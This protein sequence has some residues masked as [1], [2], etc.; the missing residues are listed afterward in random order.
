MARPFYDK[1]VTSATFRNVIGLV[2]M[3]SGEVS[4]VSLNVFQV[5]MDRKLYLQALGY[6][7]DQLAAFVEEEQAFADE[8]AT[9]RRSHSSSQESQ[10]D[11]G[12]GVITHQRQRS[13]GTLPSSFKDKLVKFVARKADLLFKKKDALNVVGVTLPEE[14]EGDLYAIM[15]PL[16]QFMGVDPALCRK[17][18]YT[19]LEQND[20]I[21]GRI[22]NM[23]D[24]GMFVRLLCLC[25]HKNRQCDNLEIVALCPTSEIPRQSSHE[26]PLSSYH[27]NDLLRTRI[28][29]V[30]PSS[31]KILLSLY[32][33]KDWPSHVDMG[34]I[35]ESELPAYY[36]RSLFLEDSDDSYDKMLHNIVGF[37]NPNCV[38]YV[39]NLLGLDEKIPPSMLRALH[40]GK[41]PENEYS[42]NLRK[43][44]T[45]KW[46]MK[47]T[48]KG[49]TLFKEGGYIEAMQYFNHALQ[50]DKQNV[51][52]L[53]AR[54]ALYANRDS[55]DKAIGDFEDALKINSIHRNARKYLCQTLI[56]KAKYYEDQS[57]ANKAISL[58]E[59][60]LTLNPSMQEAEESLQDLRRKQDIERRQ[61]LADKAEKEKQATPKEKSLMDMSRDTLK[62]LLRAEKE[63]RK[64]KK[65]KHKEKMKKKKD[66]KYYETGKESGKRGKKRKRSSSDGHGNI[67]DHGKHK[68]GKSSRQLD[69]MYDK[70]ELS[71]DDTEFKDEQHLET[72]PPKKRRKRQRS[73]SSESGSIIVM[74]VNSENMPYLQR[75][76][77]DSTSSASH[78]SQE[79]RPGKDLAKSWPNTADRRRESGSQQYTINDD[80]R[81]ASFESRLESIW[82]HQEETRQKETITKE[83][84]P[85]TKKRNSPTDE[86]RN[87]HSNRQRSSSPEILS[88]SARQ[89]HYK[90]LPKAYADDIA[91]YE[92]NIQSKKDQGYVQRIPS[93][94]GSSKRLGD[95]TDERKS[96]RRSRRSSSSSSYSLNTSYREKTQ[97]IGSLTKEVSEGISRH[98][99]HKDSRSRSPKYSSDKIHWQEKNRDGQHD[100]SEIG[101]GKK[102]SRATRAR[103]SSSSSSNR[104]TKRRNHQRKSTD[105]EKRQSLSSERQ[106]AGSD[107]RGREVRRRA[108]EEQCT[109]QERV[110]S[111]PETSNVGTRREGRPRSSGRQHSRHH[112]YESSPE[113]NRQRRESGRSTDMRHGSS[114]G[115]YNR[116]Q[117]HDSPERG[118]Q[119]HESDMGRELRHE[120]LEQ[121]H[122]RQQ[123]YDSP[124]RQRHKSEREARR[125]SSEGQK[126]RQQSHDRTER[127][128]ERHDSNGNKDVEMR[129]RSS[130]DQYHRQQSYD[131]PERQRQVHESDRGR[132]LTNRSSEG[133]SQRQQSHDNS[134]ERQTGKHDREMRRGSREGQYSR[135]Q[136]HD[137]TER[138]KQEH[139]SDRVREVR[140]RSSE[141]QYQQQQSHDSPDRQRHKS[142][143]SSEEQC[144]RQQSHDSTER[145]RQSYD[146]DIDREREARR[147]SSGNQYHGQQSYGSPERQRQAHESDMGREVRR[148]SSE[149]QSQRQQSYDNSAE[150]QRHK[151][152][153]ELRQGSTEGQYSRQQ[154]RDS[155]DGHRHKSGRDKEARRRSTEAQYSR[156]QSH[157][158]TERKR[159]RHDSDRDR[160]REGRRRSS[161]DQYRR[162]QNQDSSLEQKRHKSDKDRQMRR[163]SPEVKYTRQQSYD[164]SPEQ[165]KQRMRHASDR[166]SRRGS[167]GEQYTGQQS[168]DSLIERQRHS[169]GS[170]E[171]RRK[172]SENRSK[173]QYS[174]YDTEGYGDKQTQN[175]K[176][177]H[178]DTRTEKSD[179]NVEVELPA[180]MRRRYDGSGRKHYHS[181]ESEIIRGSRSHNYDSLESERT[182]STGLLVHSDRQT[183]AQ[184]PRLGQS[185]NTAWMEVIQQYASGTE[186]S[187]NGNSP[188]IKCDKD[189]QYKESQQSRKPSSNS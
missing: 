72:Y 174:E 78:H 127:N 37:S 48:A 102:V 157:D 80:G 182:V 82:Y 99:K 159:Q 128:T 161:G 172:S 107:D 179:A 22:I 59:K 13:S 165:H 39:T 176:S 117:S 113:I 35:S 77:K 175:V 140:R 164:S 47:S 112:S 184:S 67:E 156:Q 188:L 29:K 144:R 27:V 153:T 103:S 137:S 73:T 90:E 125:R 119:T 91:R 62:Q 149:G 57:D 12:E 68:K 94:L 38:S 178:Y 50:L 2:I 171:E 34:I 114:E 129:R 141:D 53:V 118:R 116:Q 136:S 170:K 17:R 15:P 74:E 23:R 122:Y 8:Q 135:Q 95:V 1:K 154:S 33:P 124:E 11:K 66:E 14:E 45:H 32:V 173:R 93:P 20:I 111:S 185:L 166:E 79:S 115:Q 43:E 69:K 85:V 24:F 19:L 106:R 26:S 152:D 100:K 145:N 162:Q 88:H 25:G 120:S 16:E 4:A 92:H 46:S 60:V 169:S 65:K 150:R 123:S 81:Q 110:G 42:E 134:S 44:Q 75:H 160:D 40:S 76:S 54:G 89:H 109:R 52:A 104:S 3:N 139:E 158:S 186:G 155:P 168:H 130:G 132:E 181:S 187:D 183:S 96:R 28:I 121:Q 133:Q 101:Q 49:V 131:S 31:E 87:R 21:I 138:Q 51:E 148:E 151:T 143:R 167:M 10:L 64:D 126:R 180:Y 5:N 9:R 177:Y 146:N 18:L 71:S 7:G 189:V 108:P 70:K 163:R 58:Y 97:T 63:Q 36:K 6:H 86:G 55:L 61:N 41:Y 84:L 83:H 142:D 105:L 30:E 56:V 147:R 98:S